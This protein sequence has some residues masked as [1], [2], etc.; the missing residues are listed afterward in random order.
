MFSQTGLGIDMFFLRTFKLKTSR[1]KAPASFACLK[2]YL[3]TRV[4][5]TYKGKFKSELHYEKEYLKMSEN[6]YLSPPFN[7]LIYIHHKEFITEI[8]H[9]FSFPG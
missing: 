7:L 9:I 8:L 2:S 1:K 3:V 4:A 5:D 6:I